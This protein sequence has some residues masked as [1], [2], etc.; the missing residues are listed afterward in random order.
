MWC[1]RARARGGRD[2]LIQGP[3]R[4]ANAGDSRCVIS[5]KGL[6]K[7]LSVDHRPDL[8]GARPRPARYL[9]RG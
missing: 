1:V 7:A 9:A 6:A 5:C 2:A 8:E 4:Q 3:V